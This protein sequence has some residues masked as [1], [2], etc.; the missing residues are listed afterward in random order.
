MNERIKIITQKMKDDNIDIAFFNNPMV[1]N[2]L[3][4][5]KSEPHERTLAV[6]L[7]K[8][9]D[10]LLFTPALEYE[11]AKKVTKEFEVFSYH[12]TENPWDI[13]KRKIHEINV[14][15]KTWA[16]E[17][18]FLTV[19]RKEAL[20]N[21]FPDSHIQYDFS[22]FL[23]KLRLQKT[24]DEIAIMKEAGFW[25]DEAIKIG[26]SILKTGI[27]ELEVVAQIEYELKKRGINEMSFDTM[28]LFGSNAAS[29]HG[30]PGTTPLKENQFVLF[31]LGV[32]Y[33]GYASDITRTLFFGSTP[34]DKQEKI[35]H[36]VLQAH[37]DAME[38]AALNM[39]AET[40]DGIARDIISRE[41]YGKYF[42]HR[43]GHGLGQSVH[44]FPSIMQGNT[45]PLLKNMCF[46]IEPGIYIQD[47]IGVRIEDCGFLDENGF[48]S[49]TSF[50]TNINAYREFISE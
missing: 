43:L 29:P 8:N 11:D 40:L 18:D 37:N 13:I 24:S 47:D 16:V 22:H 42:N 48:H 28:V 19:S 36:L 46:S 31:D 41:G 45:M 7:F 26:A 50:P 32:M 27:T 4:G 10:P 3:T 20:E 2:F 25:A 49:F 12:D 14:P 5:Y 38:K 33:K 6:L 44:E 34:T 35:Y 1:I 17:K 21:S 23:E 9:H 15:E 30:T 39:S